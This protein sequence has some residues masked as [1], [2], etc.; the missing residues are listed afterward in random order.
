MQQHKNA[1]RQVKGEGRNQETMKEVY[2]TCVYNTLLCIHEAVQLLPGYK[3]G[4]IHVYS[5]NRFFDVWQ[6]I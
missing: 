6:S 5:I 3:V 2:C 1:A 4:T